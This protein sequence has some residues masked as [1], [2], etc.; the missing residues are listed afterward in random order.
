MLQS[1]TDL[2]VTHE[3]DLTVSTNLYC[4][5]TDSHNY[6]LYSS[7]HPIHLLN[8]ILYS[9]FVLIECLCSKDKDFR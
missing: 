5:P 6:L 7:E 9:Q 1:K 2:H 8:G 4:K 3:T